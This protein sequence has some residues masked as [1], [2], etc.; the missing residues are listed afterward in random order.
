MRRTYLF[1][2]PLLMVSFFLSCGGSDSGGGGGSAICASNCS[3]AG[4]CSGHGGVNCSAGPDSDGSVI[5][6]DGFRDS[7]VQYQCQ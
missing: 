5:C 3:S 6:V 4:A 2:F 7:S 1:V